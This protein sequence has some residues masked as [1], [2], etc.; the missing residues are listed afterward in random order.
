MLKS[1]WSKSLEVPAR[2]TSM[3]LCLTRTGMDPNRS[4]TTTRVPLAKAKTRCSIGAGRLRD[5][6][7][8]LW[9]VKEL[10]DR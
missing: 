1:S 8:Q 3:A 5:T 7:R 2:S 6:T 10:C 9:I 4:R